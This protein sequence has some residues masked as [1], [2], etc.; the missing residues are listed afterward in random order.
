MEEDDLDTLNHAL[1]DSKCVAVVQ[2]DLDVFHPF[3]ASGVLRQV[4]SL[5]LSVA[6]IVRRDN[7]DFLTENRKALSK[8][9]HH[10]TKA[11]NC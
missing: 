7:P 3:N 1:M 6:F 4:S 8:L 9:V 2:L 11:A 5:T 10:D